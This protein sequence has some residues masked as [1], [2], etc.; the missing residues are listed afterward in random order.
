MHMQYAP[1]SHELDLFPL[2][3]TYLNLLVLRF[4]VL[5][6]NKLISRSVTL[7]IYYTETK[8]LTN[9]LYIL[10]RSLYFSNKTYVVGT[11]KNRLN[12]TVLMSAPKLHVKTDG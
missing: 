8:I 12:E 6:F 3:L 7:S 9:V 4:Y 10:R 11:K 1:L 2:L 5:L